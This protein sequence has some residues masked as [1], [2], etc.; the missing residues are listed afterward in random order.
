M[1]VS[2][3]VLMR[4]MVIG[5]FHTPLHRRQEALKVIGSLLQFADADYNQVGLAMIL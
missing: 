3:R 4:N 5:Y 1:T 2:H